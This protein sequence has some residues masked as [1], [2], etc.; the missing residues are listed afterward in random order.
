MFPSPEDVNKSSLRNIVF[1]YLELRT[2]N[3]VHAHGDSEDDGCMLIIFDVI[4]CSSI[5]GNCTIL[6]YSLCN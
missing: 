2:M 4:P 1:S 5:S 6:K 3:I